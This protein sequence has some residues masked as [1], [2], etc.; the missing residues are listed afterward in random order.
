VALKGIPR[1][2][3]RLMTKLRWRDP[4]NP[5]ETIDR[6]R[7]EMNSDYFDIL[8]MHN[9]KT[10]T[11][12]AELERLRDSLSEAKHKQL[13][14]SHGASCHGLKPLS[15]FPGN[16][17]LDVALPRVNQ[18]GTRMDNIEGDDNHGDHGAVIP[19]VKKVHSQKTGVLSMK[20]MG[21]GRFQ[22]PEQRDASVRFVMKLGAV[23]A[24]TIGFK[25]PQE[26]D[27]AIDRMNT[28]LNS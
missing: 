19:Q 20:I 8:L 10:S 1:D 3:Y 25:S 18:D 5:M 23:D 7:R 14:R 21:E 27:E 13:I 22:T 4:A 11:W 12:P 6:F 16:S 17:W 24:V 28:H 26:I 9:V 15:A 2:S